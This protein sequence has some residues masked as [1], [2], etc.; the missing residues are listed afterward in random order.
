MGWASCWSI[1][2]VQT[3]SDEFSNIN[4]IFLPHVLHCMPL[5]QRCSHHHFPVVHSLYALSSLGAYSLD[6]QPSSLG[7]RLQPMR[8]LRRSCMH[9]LE[10]HILYHE[11]ACLSTALADQLA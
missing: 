2:L 8:D 1:D 6:Q 10:M 5:K 3:F 9:L 4:Q 11:Q 7:R